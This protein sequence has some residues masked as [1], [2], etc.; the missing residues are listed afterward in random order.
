MA[1]DS[2]YLAPGRTTRAEILAALSLAIDLGLGQPMEHML[3]SSVIA[4][5]LARRLGLDEGQQGVVYYAILMAWIGCHADSHELVDWFGD[6]IAFRDDSYG[7]DWK[8]LPF[9][10]LLAT[11]VGRDQPLF[12]RAVR[13]ASLLV[14]TRG[15]LR[16]L[17]HSYCTSA[18][19][20]AERV[21]LG[22]EVSNALAY[23]FE[24]WDGGGMPHGAAGA[25]IPIEMRVVH[26]A[27]VIEVHLRRSGMDG[28]VGMARSRSG[29]QFDPAVVVAFESCADQVLGEVSVDNV[30]QAALDRAPDRDRVMTDPEIDELL[31]A[32]GAF[33][34]LKCPYL[35]GHSQ[36]VADLAARAAKCY[37]LRAPDV[38]LLYRAGLVHDLGRMGVPNSIWEKHG[39]LSD[40]DRE[41]IRLYP[42][43][44]GRILSR[45]A[46]LKDVAAVASAHHERLD[47][48]GY[49]R[50][51]SGASFT[52]AQRLLA[53]ADMYQALT[54]DR[55]YRAA[56]PA[57]AAGDLLRREVR[58]ARLDAQAVAAVLEAAGQR[59]ARRLVWP[60]GLTA[61]EVEV[62]R[63]AAQGSPNRAIAATL[64]IT[65]K[66]VRNHIER[67]YTKIGVTNRT[68]ASLYA[69]SHGL[70]DGVQREHSPET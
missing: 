6:D 58:Q 31:E 48:S 55:P 40:Y 32:V 22:T 49:P 33:A 57:A 15:H 10:G 26:L 17:I 25:E 23:A 60:D 67:V 8:G 69:L 11:H 29:T 63:L 45:V 61:R 1:A 13:A 2:P 38:Q 56:H 68:G 37:G 70:L 27:D 34:D 21:G 62:L 47:G 3:R 16:E 43:L 51:L 20:L 9:L 42:Y 19:V 39:P 24:R 35:A 30:W 54:E 64:Q 36:R 46:G 52:S 4:T 59:V 5:S 12:A 66:T 50:G 53:A 41:R 14:N 18:G 44:T 7:V 28:A 65:E